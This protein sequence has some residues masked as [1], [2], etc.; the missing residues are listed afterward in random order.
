MAFG[1]FAPD[2]LA[3]VPTTYQVAS[4]TS[5]GPWQPQTSFAVDQTLAAGWGDP[6]LASD[7]RGA[8]TLVWSISYRAA[9][10]SNDVD[11]RTFAS[12]TQ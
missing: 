4:R 7:R 8:L 9:V 10:G 2:D 12:N 1:V 6:W 3:G 11:W 5:T